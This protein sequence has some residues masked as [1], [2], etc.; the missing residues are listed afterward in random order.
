VEEGSVVEGN[1]RQIEIVKVT[2]LFPFHRLPWP[3]RLANPSCPS[4]SH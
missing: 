1:R 3:F 2:L 4:L